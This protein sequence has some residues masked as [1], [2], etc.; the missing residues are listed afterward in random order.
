M[1][2]E[3]NFPNIIIDALKRSIK[4]R[5]INE[6]R[7]PFVD[8][9]KKAMGL[10]E[11]DCGKHYEFELKVNTVFDKEI[12]DEITPETLDKLVD[13]VAQVKK[14]NHEKLSMLEFDL[15]NMKAALE[16]NL[17]EDANSPEKG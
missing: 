15:W 9:V 7:K 14:F 4:K 13:Y 11:C 17:K 6:V 5:D 2:K 8:L 1:T 12:V 16:N 10:K 3:M